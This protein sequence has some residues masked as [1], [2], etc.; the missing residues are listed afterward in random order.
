MIEVPL[1]LCFCLSRSRH[2]SRSGSLSLS[3]SL[4]LSLSLSPSLYLAI[5][6]SIALTPRR[7]PG[8]RRATQG[9]TLCLS[10]SA[11]LCFPR[12]LSRYIYFSH[13]FPHS[14]SIALTPRAMAGGEPH[15]GARL[16]RP[17]RLPRRAG[18]RRR[19][20]L[21]LG[22]TLTRPPNIRSTMMR[23]SKMKRTMV[24]P[25]NIRRTTTRPF[26]LRRTMARPSD[27]RRT[28][29]RPSRTL[30]RDKI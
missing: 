6:R 29:T 17:L 12:A 23:P 16:A 7:P 15:R 18:P 28:M 9:R 2:V 25:F 21:T 30:N 4:Y 13:P 3:L 22:R 1:Y 10:L 14:L 26:S 27:I 5:F 8:R 11:S 20:L 19:V 24:R